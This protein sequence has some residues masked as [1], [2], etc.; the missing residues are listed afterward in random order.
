MSDDTHLQ[1]A[2]EPPADDPSHAPE[3]RQ[4]D[5]WIGEWDVTWGEGE[6]GTN[7]IESILNDRVILENFDGNPAMP[8]RG[9]SVSVYSPQRGCWQ[10]T[11]VDDTGNYWAFSGGFADRRMTLAT[12]DFVAGQ[13]VKRRMVW[14]NIAPDSLD[15]NWERSDDG[16]ATWK[17]LWALHYRRRS[18]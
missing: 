12:D 2:D 3:A 11:W 5:F 17:V 9:M 8:F 6:R 18:R 10:Q 4:F 14:Y 15:W 13:P 16:G 1:A 7:R